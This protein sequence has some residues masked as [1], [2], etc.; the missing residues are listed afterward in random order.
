MLAFL[1]VGLRNT[2]CRIFEGSGPSSS[3][4]S[5]A[6]RLRPLSVLKVF[7]LVSPRLDSCPPAATARIDDYKKTTVSQ[8]LV[9]R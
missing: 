1:L 2:G 8:R 9:E 4:A 7:P 5:A 3:A 6:V